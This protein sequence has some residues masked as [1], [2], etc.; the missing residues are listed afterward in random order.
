MV[1]FMILC[2]FFLFQ[3]TPGKFEIQ[4]RE[5]RCILRIV[6]AQPDDEAEYSCK[7]GTASTAADVYVIGT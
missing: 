4:R 7:C 5:N 2:F 1:C 3:Y 6:N